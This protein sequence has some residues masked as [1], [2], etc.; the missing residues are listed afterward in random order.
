MTIRFA[1]SITPLLLLCSLPAS[2]Q[3]SPGGGVPPKPSAPSVA[4]P[5]SLIPGQ[6]SGN[7]IDSTP[8]PS[9]LTADNVRYEGGLIIAEGSAAH[10]ARFLSGAG[11]I[12]AQSVRIDTANRSI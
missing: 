6:N 2:A 9:R 1:A 12:T 8:I 10:P 4:P 5:I 7:A 3:N 11:E